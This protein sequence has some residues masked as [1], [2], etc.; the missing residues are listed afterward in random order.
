MTADF[1]LFRYHLSTWE[2][3]LLSGNPVAPRTM[4]VNDGVVLVRRCIRLFS[5]EC[6]FNQA[7]KAQEGTSKLSVILLALLLPNL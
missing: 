7:C 4:R 5:R 1:K 3:M 6:P 2:T